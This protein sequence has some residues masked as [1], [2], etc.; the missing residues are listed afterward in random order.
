M[1]YLQPVYIFSTILLIEF[2]G[3]RPC[4]SASPRTFWASG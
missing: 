1:F 2:E 3:S 4:T